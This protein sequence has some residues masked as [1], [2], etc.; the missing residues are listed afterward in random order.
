M[1][2]LISNSYKRYCKGLQDLTRMAPRAQPHE[3]GFW[4][5]SITITPIP[6]SA[7]KSHYRCKIPLPLLDQP[8]A[9]KCIDCNLKSPKTTKFN[10]HIDAVHMSEVLE[11]LNS[12]S[13]DQHYREIDV[14]ERKECETAF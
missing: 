2:V 13:L 4:R 11:H 6:T 8:S 3:K 1:F 14:Y 10:K 5:P 9:S 12:G 7:T